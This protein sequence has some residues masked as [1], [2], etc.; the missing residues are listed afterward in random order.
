MKIS[1]I[2]ARYANKLGVP[3]K[4]LSQQVGLDGWG[5]WHANETNTTGRFIGTPYTHYAVVWDNLPAT[6]GRVIYY[7]NNFTNKILLVN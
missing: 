2:C 7:H 5:G 3:E 6:K 1:R 4:D